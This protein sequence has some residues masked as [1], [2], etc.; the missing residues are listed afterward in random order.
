MRHSM[1]LNRRQTKSWGAC[2]AGRRPDKP[3]DAVGCRNNKMAQ[4]G[5]GLEK[6]CM[7]TKC[8]DRS[9]N[10]FICNKSGEAELRSFTTFILAGVQVGQLA[11]A[12]ARHS[13]TKCQRRCQQRAAA[14]APAPAAG[15]AAVPAAAGH[16][17]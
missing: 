7:Q 12:G 15:V 16:R 4:R 10:T 8:S 9:C 13:S 3:A 6:Q 2:R 1:L 17:R 5:W 14:L 11:T